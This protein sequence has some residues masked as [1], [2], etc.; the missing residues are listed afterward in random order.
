MLVEI[1]QINNY[2]QKNKINIDRKNIGINAIVVEIYSSIDTASV[3]D[4]T[5]SRATNNRNESDSMVGLVYK[6]SSNLYGGSKSKKASIPIPK[7]FDY[8]EHKGGYITIRPKEITQ[9]EEETEEYIYDADKETITYIWVP[10]TEEDMKADANESKLTK[11]RADILKEYQNVDS[12]IDIDKLRE[13]Y[14]SIK[15]DWSAG[16]LASIRKYGGFYISEA[17]LSTDKQDNYR[18]IARGMKNRTVKE[19]EDGGNYYRGNKHGQYTKDVVLSDIEGMLDCRI[20]AGNVEMESVSSH[21]MYGVEYDATLR[22]ILETYPNNKKEI[23]INS[24]EVGK[25][26]NTK[27][28]QENATLSAQKSSK[29]YN[30]IWG[31]GGNLGEITQEKSGDKNQYYV[32]R[33]GSYESKGE[34][35]PI[36]SINITE[37]TNKENLGYRTALYIKASEEEVKEAEKTIEEIKKQCHLGKLE[38]TKTAGGYYKI[39]YYEGDGTDEKLIRENEKLRQTLISVVKQIENV[40]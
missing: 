24:T 20:L 23:L 6:T 8:C 1:A 27:V 40:L 21:L 32:I 34:D 19:T 39:A 30:G 2:L 35:E 3:E 11:V 17:E 31:L 13:K 15:E 9:R 36:A 37:D 18:N 12:N 22:W 25:Y 14:V 10:L 28:V 5:S 4:T 33:G 16:F 26:T 29:Y 38:Y 7:G